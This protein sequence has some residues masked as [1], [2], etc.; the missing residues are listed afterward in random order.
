MQYSTNK[1][2]NK[3]VEQLIDRIEEMNPYAPQPGGTIA[4]VIETIRMGFGDEE[5]R[6]VRITV[7]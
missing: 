1:R 3:A 4:S 6:G 2:V 7:H 5:A